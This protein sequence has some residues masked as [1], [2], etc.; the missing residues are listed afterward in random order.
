MF[1]WFMICN[2]LLYVISSKPHPLIIYCH[3]IYFN[4]QLSAKV[5]QISF[6]RQAGG[7]GGVSEDKMVAMEGRLNHHFQE[8]K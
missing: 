2:H 3:L 1:D 4:R 6:G 8:L 7:V 5:D